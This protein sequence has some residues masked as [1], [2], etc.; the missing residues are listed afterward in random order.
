MKKNSITILTV[1]ILIFFFIIGCD[2]YHRDRYTGTWEFITERK[3]YNV[4]DNSYELVEIKRDT[5]YYIG[6]IT[7]SNNENQIIIQY[8]KNDEINAGIDKD[9]YIYHETNWGG[10]YA[11]GQFVNSKKLHLRLPWGEFVMFEGDTDRRYDHIIGTK[12]GRRQNE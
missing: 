1:I 12:N 9:G 4:D 10:K 8:T 11:A 7:M 6:K 2:K 5:V 3:Y